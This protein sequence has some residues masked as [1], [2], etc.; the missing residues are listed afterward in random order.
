MMLLK[1]RK[2]HGTLVEGYK[3]CFSID[4]VMYVVWVMVHWP[5]CLLYSVKLIRTF[6]NDY[7]D[8]V[9]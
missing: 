1:V 6:H 3:S 5:R 8:E 2:R 9:L 4:I 7:N